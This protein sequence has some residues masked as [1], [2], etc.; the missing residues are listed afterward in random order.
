MAVIHAGAQ[1]YALTTLTE[2][3]AALNAGIL[4][5]P[6]PSWA[7]FGLFGV[8][9]VVIGGLVSGTIFGLNLILSCSVFGVNNNDA[10]SA[11]RRNSHRH[12][13]RMRI[14]D[15]LT[16]YPIKLDKVPR[17]KDWR[18]NTAPNTHPMFTTKLAPDLIEEPIVID[19]STVKSTREIDS[20]SATS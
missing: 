3:F 11:I 18:K 2:W 9:M 16:I 15:D 7:W 8:E 4:S 12:F 10:F 1:W 20:D 5:G 17:R 6:P 19:P 13:L 14:G